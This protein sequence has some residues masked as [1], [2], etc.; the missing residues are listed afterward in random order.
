MET[1]ACS[2]ISNA[3]ELQLF[4]AFCMLIYNNCIITQKK[5][6]KEGY[7][8]VIGLSESMVD[9]FSKDFFAKLDM[10]KNLV[11]CLVAKRA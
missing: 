6:L 3:A 2:Q 11:P 4:A 10:V 8:W 5:G 9:A 1:F 7:L